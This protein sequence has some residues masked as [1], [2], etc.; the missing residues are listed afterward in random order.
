MRSGLF[1]LTMFWLFVWTVI[2]FGVLVEMV[3]DFAGI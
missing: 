1:M 3:M 2:T